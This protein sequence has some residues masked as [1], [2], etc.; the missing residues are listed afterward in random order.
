MGPSFG[1]R[2]TGIKSIQRGVTTIAN[3]S[4]ST[5]AIITP[6]DLT[7]SVLFYLGS[8]TASTAINDACARVSFS[9]NSGV[10][11]RRDNNVSPTDVSWQI[12]E[13]Y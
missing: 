5:T 1:A 3:A 11:C 13:Y 7:K 4:L 12:V 10:L 8:S 6:V 2:P 9:S